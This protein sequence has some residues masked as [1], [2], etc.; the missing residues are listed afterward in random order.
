[1]KGI[2]E[3][4]DHGCCYIITVG[5]IVMFMTVDH[6]LSLLLLWLHIIIGIFVVLLNYSCILKG[7]R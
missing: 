1:M 2:G 3:V 6:I 4:Y 5:V 7:D